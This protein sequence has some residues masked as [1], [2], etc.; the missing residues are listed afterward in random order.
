MACW[1]AQ[2]GANRATV[3]NNI[4]SGM[5]RNNNGEGE[6]ST[7]KSEQ[8][9]SNMQARKLRVANTNEFKRECCYNYLLPKYA[10]PESAAG[11]FRFP[12]YF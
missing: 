4:F 2:L 12:G 7:I 3:E 10:Q 6:K 8:T 5:S 1:S 11:H 9:A